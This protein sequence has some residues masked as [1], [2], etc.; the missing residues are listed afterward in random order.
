[1]SPD[2][3]AL[4]RFGLRDPDDPRVQNT[5]CVIDAVLATELPV[6][7][8]WRRYPD[9]EYGEHEDGTAFDGHGSGRPWPLLIGERAHYELAR[10]HR[11]TAIRLLH[12]MEACVSETGMLPEQVWDGPDIPARGL[13]RGRATR[14]A[15]PLGWAH[16]EYMKLCR[17]LADDRVFDLPSTRL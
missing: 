16:A 13:Y 15:A 4:V 17:S 3:L 5:V 8:A 10:G 9:D 1:V 2:A 7:P 14:S 6:G 12:A 11:G